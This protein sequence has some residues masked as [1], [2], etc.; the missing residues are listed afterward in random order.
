[1]A[2]GDLYPKLELS[3]SLGVEAADFSNL[4]N[5]AGTYRFGPSL[6]WAPLDTGRLRARVRAQ[7][8]RTEGA[9]YAYEQAVLL[10]LEDVENSLARFSA[11]KLRLVNL[12]N[13]FA[14]A[15]RAH[16]LA[17]DQYQEGVTDFLSVLDSQKVMLDNESNLIRGEKSIAVSLVGVYK[18]LGGGWENWKLGSV[19]K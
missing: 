19:E 4:T 17:K 2:T 8:A 3:G 10:A 9:L 1:V 7:D 11:E 18:A 5:G 12:R 6:T 13:A 14:A 15:Q 16:G